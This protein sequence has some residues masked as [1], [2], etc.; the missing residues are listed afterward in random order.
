M[1]F[2]TIH[3][4][5]E[6]EK[7][8]VL[9][10]R[11]KDSGQYYIRKF[12]QGRH[13]V[14]EVLKS[15]S[16]PYLPRI[17]EA[18]IGEDRAIILEEYIE[19]LSAGETALSEKKVRSVIRELCSVLEYLHGKGIVHRDIKPSNL[20]LAQDGHIR[21][22]DFDAARV[23]RE[24]A[25]QDTRL[26]GTRGYA[27]PEQYG[28]MQTDARTDIYSL[29]V[30]FQQLLGESEKKACYQRIIRKCTNF[31]PDKRYLS[32]KQL[33]RALLFSRWHLPGIAAAVVATVFLLNGGGQFLPWNDVPQENVEHSYPE[34]PKEELLLY[35]TDGEYIQLSNKEMAD[36]GKSAQMRVDMTGRG[37][38]VD[39]SIPYSLNNWVEYGEEFD[40]AFYLGP[41]ADGIAA[42]FWQDGEQVSLWS[43]DVDNAY[44]SI[45]QDPFELSEAGQ[46][47]LTCVDMDSD[48]VKELLVSQGD[49]EHALVTT[50]WQLTDVSGKKF[51]LVGVTWGTSV[52]Y[53]YA[54]GDIRAIVNSDQLNH[55]HYENG[56]LSYV[57]GVD[58][59][60]FKAA[61]K[62]PE[63]EDIEDA[64]GEPAL[65]SP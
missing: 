6:S 40:L 47:Q 38:K 15:C 36:D 19:G 35:T 55:Y 51:E 34:Y 50:V 59:A 46:V 17:Y 3:R 28:F 52:M 53:L 32:V 33:K 49:R 5:K 18:D 29:G 64:E 60:D 54:D 20:L 23:M 43:T 9:L 26:L 27:S 41:L 22:I 62:A 63:Q 61:Q 24:E 56:V 7:S 31:D 13:S 4:I 21:L 42:S 16:H 12:L 11:E 14:Y 10:V 37:D 57:S 58:F 8:T 39:F 65:P 1:E 2:E 30:T 48:G 25:E 45:P 44:R